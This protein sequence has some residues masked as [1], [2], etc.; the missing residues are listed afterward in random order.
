MES[1]DRDADNMDADYQITQSRSGANGYLPVRVTNL[2][3]NRHF[4]TRKRYGGNLIL[5]YRLPSGSIKFV[6][7]LS[8]LNSQYKEYRTKYDYAGL[9]NDLIFTYREGDNNVDLALNSLGF[10]YDLG[11]M[12]VDLKAANK[13]SRNNLPEVPQSEFRQTKRSWEFNREYY[14]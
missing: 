5:D 9:T 10:K 12:T 3:L 14:S 11:F 8:R 13:Y 7:L 6:N 4:E 1:Y 2:T